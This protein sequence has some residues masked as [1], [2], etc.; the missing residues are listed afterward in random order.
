MALTREAKESVVAEMNNL[1]SATKITVVAKY[2]GTT[3]QEIQQLRRQASETNTDLKIAKNRLVIKAMSNHE[4]LKSAD[5]SKL[6][7]QLL[8]AFNADDEVAPAQVLYAFSK[9]HPQIE[10]VGAYSDDGS[11]M[12]AE[13]VSQLAQL[14]SKEQLRAQLV[15][16]IAAPISGFV[17]VLNG[18]LRGFV[19]VLNARAQEMEG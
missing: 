12:D 1:L 13:Q 16:T 18:N 19:N 14:P 7:G 2:T 10:F 4:T 11:W 3:V 6:E 17:N 8:Y 5:T 9:E 15:G